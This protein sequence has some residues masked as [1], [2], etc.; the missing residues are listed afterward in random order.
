MAGREI[1]NL[2]DLTFV[3]RDHRPGDVVQ[4]IVERGGERQE[5]AATL[6]SRAKMATGRT[7][8][9][10]GGDPPHSPHAA[11][12][13]PPM[14]PDTLLYPGEEK[15]LKNLRQLTFEGENAEAYFAL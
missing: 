7:A 10:Q 12:S 1:Q 2:Y 8:H 15:F 9:G 11:P 4:V 14:D 13:V 5:L 6:G 3:L